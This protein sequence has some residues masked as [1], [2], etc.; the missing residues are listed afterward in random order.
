VTFTI[1]RC[2]RLAA[3]ADDVWAHA[4]TMEGVNAELGPWVR[5]SVPRAARGRTIDAAPIGR[6]AFASVL[7]ALGVV[8]FDVHHLVLVEVREHAFVEESWSWMQRRWRHERAITELDRGCEIVDRVT[9]EPRLPV[10]PI[11]RRVV[12]A[13]FE[14]RHRVLR[15]RFGSLVDGA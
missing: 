7:L 14:R 3:S 6:E 9:V 5:M 2:S 12:L 8:P 10:D 13:I 4:R 15:A 1:E 11:A